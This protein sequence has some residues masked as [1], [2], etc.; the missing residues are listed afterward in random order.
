MAG[1][2]SLES[3]EFLFQK[4]S[5]ISNQISPHAAFN[6]ASAVG[7]AQGFIPQIAPDQQ[8]KKRKI[9]LDYN[10]IYRLWDPTQIVLTIAKLKEKG[11]EFAFIQKGEGENIFASSI[12]DK[13]EGDKKYDY[14]FKDKNGKE[15]GIFELSDDHIKENFSKLDHEK[16]IERLGLVRDESIILSFEQFD[17]IHK[18]FTQEHWDDKERVSVRSSLS[19]GFLDGVLEKSQSYD[20]I[21]H[22]ISNETNQFFIPDYLK[23]LL[24]HEDFNIAD[25]DT[26]LALEKLKELKNN[27]FESI[28]HDIKN[29]KTLEALFD[30]ISSYS[31]FKND[32]AQDNKAKIIMQKSILKELWFKCSD[33]ETVVSRA[34][35]LDE[36]KDKTPHDIATSIYEDLSPILSNHILLTPEPLSFD[37]LERCPEKNVLDI[38]NF[39]RAGNI[40]TF[41]VIAEQRKKETSFGEKIKVKFAPNADGESFEFSLKLSDKE[42]KHSLTLLHFIEIFSN[43]EINQQFN[44][45]EQFGDK[46]ID[47]LKKKTLSE[48][49]FLTSSNNS[50]FL[51]QLNDGQKKQFLD[52]LHDQVKTKNCLDSI[53]KEDAVSVLLILQYHLDQPEIL[54]F[55]KS[56]LK[57]TRG[58]KIIYFSVPS[59]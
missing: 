24:T 26:F 29:E 3:L 48:I 32:D 13:A 6:P 12:E 33:F 10:T 28:L 22:L 5:S 38:F 11:F 21:L 4:K 42:H 14:K 8:P 51:E 23:D 35:T 44:L 53:K 58:V 56:V 41:S 9:Y 54:K 46:I 15:I 57:Q 7:G 55:A 27:N 45:T 25:T 20:D 36:F 40:L 19:Y 30:K 18:V 37:I 2:S 1:F 39:I 34:K 16:S 31:F 43:P 49:C 47:L 59:N 17:Q 52:L 50:N